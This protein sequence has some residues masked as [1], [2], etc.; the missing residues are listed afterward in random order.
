VLSAD[1]F[2]RYAS[3]TVANTLGQAP[4][5]LV[6]RCALEL[7]HP[8]DR[9]RVGRLFDELRE[10]PGA[11]R[12]VDYRIQDSAGA[13]RVLEGTVTT[14]LAAAGVRGMVCNFRDVTERKRTEDAQQLLAE[15]GAV[16]SSSLDDGATLD[17]LARLAV[18]LL[19]DLCLIDM[20]Q[21]DG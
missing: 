3:P 8:D 20:V 21:D 15:T 18:R 5:A 7:I 2:V 10:E 9:E 1:G 16:L 12:G 4:E 11:A 14:L 13:W 6:G 19:A 17:A